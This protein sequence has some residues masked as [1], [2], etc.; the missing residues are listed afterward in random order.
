[1]KNRKILAFIILSMCCTGYFQAVQAATV[2]VWK[3][4]A[5]TGYTPIHWVS[6]RG[7]QSFVKSPAGNGY[8]DY[9]T[10]I[11]L[12]YN[13]I[14]LFTSST[15]RVEFGAGTAPLSDPSIRN[16]AFNRVPAEQAKIAN[17]EAQFV[18]NA[19]YFNVTLPV[20]DLSLGL[21]SVDGSSTYITSG[22]RPAI[23]MAQP[24]R[25]LIVDNKT[26]T[27][28]VSD[29]NEADFVRNGDQAVEGFGPLVVKS[30]GG[31]TARVYAGVR[32]AGKELV[33]YC[34]R[35]ANA[36]EVSNELAVAGVQLSEQIQLDGGGSSA[37]GYNL[38][39]QYFVE[40]GRTL[41]H[42]MGAFGFL[43]KATVN[44]ALLNV[45]SGPST[46][47]STVRQLT[48]GASLTAYEEKNGWVRISAHQEW[49]LGTLLKK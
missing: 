33:I 35:S 23:D 6:A 29:F 25:M 2:P 43:Y 14:K 22:S 45:R 5:P 17:P 34:S 20:T 31:T 13:E 46:K 16:W 11:Y 7:V 36:E 8:S 37:C 44:A 39:G 15:A 28:V 19:P 41:P 40:P 30:D 49:V 10:F 24:R 32:A 18:W 4:V 42:L 9:L 48:R 12:P 21:K 38:P 3:P 26:N 27:A 47:N 1:M